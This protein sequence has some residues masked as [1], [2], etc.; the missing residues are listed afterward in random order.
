MSVVGG[1][2]G[3]AVLGKD[4]I[5]LLGREVDAAR[6]GISRIAKSGGIIELEIILGKEHSSAGL[7]A[8]ENL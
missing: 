7:A 4:F 8:V 2:N 3:L 6:R 5:S 1:K